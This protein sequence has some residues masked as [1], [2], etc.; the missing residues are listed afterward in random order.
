MQNTTVLLYEWLIFCCITG[1]A[2]YDLHYHRVPD[3]ALVFFFPLVLAA[4]LFHA[5]LIYAPDIRLLTFG[6]SL[7]GAA[8]GFFI[9]LTAALISKKG[10]GIGGGDIKLAALMGFIYGPYRILAILLIASLLALIPAHTAQKKHP[11]TSMTLPFV[12]FLAIGTLIIMITNTL[13][14]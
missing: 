9:L 6:F 4:P 10:V 3:R 1:F 11:G 14:R 7:T 5:H 2:A 13:C 12:P 8:T